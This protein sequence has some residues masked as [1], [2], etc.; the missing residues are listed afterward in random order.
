MSAA[1]DPAE[2]FTARA[3]RGLAI[4][5]RR[6]ALGIAQP[7]LAGVAGVSVAMVGLIDAAR[8]PSTRG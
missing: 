8:C 7:A 1:V 6:M 5:R 2:L 3:R 4:R